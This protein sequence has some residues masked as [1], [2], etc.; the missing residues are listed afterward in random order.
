MAAVLLSVPLLVRVLRQR[1]KGDVLGLQERFL[2]VSVLLGLLP[3]VVA[4]VFIDRTNRDWLTEDARIQTR[5]GLETGP[6]TASGA[7]GGTGARPGGQ[8]LHQRSAGK[9]PE[10]FA[11]D[12]ALRHASGHG[13]SAD[14][15]L[16]LDE[17]LSDLDDTEARLLLDQALAASLVI[18]RDEGELYLGTVIPVALEETQDVAA[19]E[20][21]VRRHARARHAPARRFL[22]LPPAS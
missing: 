16:L 20:G 18:V 12:G 11:S 8:R 3:L 7:A 1:L 9:P 17:T 21:L 15:E 2:I 4:G 19:V 5:E 10:R 6:R 14:G 22:L 13:V